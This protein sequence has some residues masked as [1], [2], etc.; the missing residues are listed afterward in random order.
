MADVATAATPD[1]PTGQEHKYH[2]NIV[3]SCGGC[4]GAVD[5]VLKKLEGVKSY[6]VSLETQTATVIAEDS[7]PYEKVLKTIAKTGKKV[8]KGEADGEERSVEVPKDE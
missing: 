6:T 3:M 4:S 2:F 7:L 8:T 5:R 1:V